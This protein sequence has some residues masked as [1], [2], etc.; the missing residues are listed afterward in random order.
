MLLFPPLDSKLF[1]MRK[2]Y[3]KLEDLI[4]TAQLAQLSLNETELEKVFPAFEQMISFFS[5]MQ[6]A[7]ADQSAFKT[8]I[9]ELSEI[10]N[11]V[12]VVKIAEPSGNF[13]FE[14]PGQQPEHLKDIA[15]SY[16]CHMD[17]VPLDAMLQ[18]ELNLHSMAILD[19]G[20][21]S[22]DSGKMELVNNA[23]WHIG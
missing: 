11:G 9:T 5:T 6:T 3:M 22:A 19:A 12:S 10:Q 1:F 17:G 20:V 13:V 15:W 14:K 21:R 18:P 16:V 23:V 2:C 8:P 4:E 7:E